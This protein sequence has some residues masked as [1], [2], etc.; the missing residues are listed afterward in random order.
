[1]RRAVP[2]LAATAG[3]LALLANFRTT[4]Q[5]LGG[6]TTGVLT[7]PSTST[8]VPA[9]GQA[10]GPTAP[11]TSPSTTA[12]SAPTTGS[13]PPRTT[14]PPTTASATRSVDGP[15]VVTRYGDVQVRVTLR[16]TRIEDVQAL[17]LPNERQRS[18]EISQYAGPQLRQ[19][20]LQAQSANINVVSGASYTSQGYAQSL[21]GALD[22]AH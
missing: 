13:A 22:A 12:P 21:Q 19:E 11:G 15:D 7:T 5:A 14:V 10:S 6:T 2:V 8:S 16:G 17:L 20:A 1:M 9:D 3:G 4:P 18:A